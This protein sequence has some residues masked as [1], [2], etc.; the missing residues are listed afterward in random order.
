MTDLTGILGIIV[1]A[2]FGIYGIWDARD[3]R[4]RKDKSLRVIR[5]VAHETRGLAIG[6]KPWLTDPKQTAAINDLIAR[7]DIA[8]NDDASASD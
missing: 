8:L 5:G 1:S 7:V 3:Q 2:G 4:V 6:I